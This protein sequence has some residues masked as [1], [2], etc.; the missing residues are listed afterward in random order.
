[1]NSLGLEA[2]EASSCFNLHQLPRLLVFKTTSSKFDGS[3]WG[4]SKI[5]GQLDGVIT[6]TQRKKATKPIYFFCRP[7]QRKEHMR[8]T[9]LLL[10]SHHFDWQQLVLSPRNMLVH[11]QL[12]C[13]WAGSSVIILDTLI[14]DVLLSHSTPEANIPQDGPLLG[15]IGRT[16]FKSWYK[17]SHGSLKP[18]MAMPR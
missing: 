12:V 9:R 15:D 16:V 13:A 3:T 4:H 2:C 17:Y 8:H 14:V 1:M 6:S 7:N 5:S 18:D 11:W 10:V